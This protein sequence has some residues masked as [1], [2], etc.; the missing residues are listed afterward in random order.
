MN[1]DPGWG[2]AV[3]GV[4]WGLVPH[5]TF[6]R[7]RR[8]AA[9]G[10]VHGLLALRAGFVAFV[11][12][13]GL[14][15]ATVVVMAVGGGLEPDDLPLG[16]VALGVAAV[17]V[18]NQVGMRSLGRE[19]DCSSDH[20]LAS[21]YATRFFLR[22]AFSNASALVGFVAFIVTGEPV[23]YVVGLAFTVV[24]LRYSMPTAGNLARD[25]YELASGGCHRSLVDALR[26]G[27]STAE[28]H[29]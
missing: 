14:V 2:W 1:E 20:A 18:L 25:Q 21:S 4:G 11:T 27:L 29:E 23:M 22:M 6:H 12:L 10:D 15:S 17:G 5:M 7:Y 8:I 9:R 16:L 26:R 24:G 3:R 13:V 28:E 19:L